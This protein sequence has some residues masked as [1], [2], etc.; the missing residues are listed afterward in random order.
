MRYPDTRYR[1]YRG[2]H[3]ILAEYAHK[4][5][6]GEIEPEIIVDMLAHKPELATTK[7]SKPTALL[8]GMALK[9]I[10]ELG[11]LPTIDQEIDGKRLD[12]NTPSG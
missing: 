8:V 4:P 3:C 5:S 11:P 1:Q 12:L 10:H 2:R 7:P 6:H 9:R